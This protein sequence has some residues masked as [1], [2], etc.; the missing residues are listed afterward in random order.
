MK[1]SIAV[2]TAL[3]ALSAASPAVAGYDPPGLLDCP[4]DQPTAKNG[5]APT[6]KLTVK[7]IR[8]LFEHPSSD[9]DY[10]VKITVEKYKLG[11]KRKWH[12]NSAGFGDDGNGKPGTWVWPIKATWTRRGYAS[13]STLTSTDISIFNC[14]VNTFDEWECGLADTIKEGEIEYKPAVTG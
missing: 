13:D 6:K 5:K 1:R 10:A 3:V 14:Y 2:C 11:H 12:Q 4:I 9:T 8:C 7:V